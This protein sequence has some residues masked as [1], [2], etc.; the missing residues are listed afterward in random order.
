MEPTALAHLNNRIELPHSWSDVSHSKRTDPIRLLSFHR[1]VIRT[2]LRIIITLNR[3]MILCIHAHP[4]SKRVGD[5][6]VR[7]SGN[8]DTEG[9]SQDSKDK[10]NPGNDWVSGEVERN[11]TS[12]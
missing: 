8:G 7:G 6:V 12:S 11:M 2:S 9:F 10:L 1:Y 4:C 5:A 3:Y